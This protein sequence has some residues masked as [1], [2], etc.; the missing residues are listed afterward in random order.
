MKD[1]A[2]ILEHIHEYFQ[3]DEGMVW[4]IIKDDIPQFLRN[5]RTIRDS[6]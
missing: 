2:I 6:L 4:N 1:N 3:I 5:I